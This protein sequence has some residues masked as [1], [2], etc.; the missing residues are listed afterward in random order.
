M[1]TDVVLTLRLSQELFDEVQKQA[2]TTKKNVDSLAAAAIGRGLKISASKPI[3]FDDD[4]RRALEGLL[5]KN[6]KDADDVL[7][8]IKRSLSIK[9]NGCEVSI[10]PMVIQR[11]QNRCYGK[12]FDKFLPEFIQIEIERAVGL[13]G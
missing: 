13:R 3:I 2:Q 5:G 1:P 7:A 6:F 12:T 4:Q 10:K 9:L 11:L 8:Y